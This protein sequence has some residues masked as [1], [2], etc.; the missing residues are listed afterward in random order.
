MSGV[1]ALSGL[2]RLLTAQLRREGP[3]TDKAD[4]E[5]SADDVRYVIINQMDLY[6]VNDLLAEYGLIDATQEYTLTHNG[7]LPAGPRNLLSWLTLEYWDFTSAKNKITA[8][9][10]ITITPV[11]ST[12]CCICS[13]TDTEDFEILPCQHRVHKG[14]MDRWT[15]DCP[16]CRGPAR[17]AKTSSV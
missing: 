15:K 8:P 5:S 13:E 9:P 7:Y 4:L 11:D 1:S 10:Q 14:C 3:F 12:Y 17:W 16:L 2:F 6:R